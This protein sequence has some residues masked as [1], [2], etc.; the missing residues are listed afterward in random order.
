MTAPAPR[1]GDQPTSQ[2]PGPW[3][4][5][6]TARDH[7]GREYHLQG[8]PH[9]RAY[10]D[11]LGRHHKARGTSIST[12]GTGGNIGVINAV[13]HRDQ[14]PR[15]T[16]TEPALKMGAARRGR[17]CAGRASST[18]GSTPSTRLRRTSGHHPSSPGMARNRRREKS[19]NTRSIQ[20]PAIN[21]ASTSAIS[22]GIKL[23]VISWIWVAAW[24][25]R[26]EQAHDQGRRS[27]MAGQHHGQEQRF[28][29]DVDYRFRRHGFP[30][31][32][33]SCCK[34]PGNQGPAVDKD[35]QHQF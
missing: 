21:S 24:K 8:E 20:G 9:R 3:S 6:G 12:S 22:F 11:L 16:G 15:R 19:V 28:V 25:T 32:H 34:R 27:T 4:W 14:H 29:A 33:E 30:S 17:R 2:S 35:E 23:S 7:H 13:R 18:A 1:S 31:G 5:P 26:H 10:Q